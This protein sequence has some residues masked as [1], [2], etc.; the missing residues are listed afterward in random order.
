MRG[1]ENEEKVMHEE[2]TELMTWMKR[3]GG[4]RVMLLLSWLEGERRSGCQER[5]SGLARCDPGMWIR[6]RSKSARS[7]SQQA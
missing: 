2:R 5:A 7:K 1:S 3:E 4:R 6:Q